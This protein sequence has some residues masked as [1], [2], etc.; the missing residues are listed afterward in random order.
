MHVSHAVYTRCVWLE[1][2]SL[3]SLQLLRDC[4]A[5]DGRLTLK[6]T[7]GQVGG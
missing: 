3:F 6:L 1:C 5:F 7:I 2:L 4:F